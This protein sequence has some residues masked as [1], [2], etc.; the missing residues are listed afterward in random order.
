MAILQLDFHGCDSSCRESTNFTESDKTSASVRKDQRSKEICFGQTKRN[1]L[2]E[3]ALL[4]GGRAHAV[5]AILTALNKKRI[6]LVRTKSE[7][8]PCQISG[9]EEFPQ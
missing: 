7:R 1:C 9:T 2:R 8:N 5:V 4:L 6:R 3:I